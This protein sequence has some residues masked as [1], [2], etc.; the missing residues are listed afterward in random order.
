MLDY[1]N[2]FQKRIHDPAELSK[3]IRSEEEAMYKANPE[4]R[5]AG[6]RLSSLEIPNAF[7]S[8]EYAPSVLNLTPRQVVS[9]HGAKGQTQLAKILIRDIEESRYG[10]NGGFLTDIQRQEIKRVLNWQDMSESIKGITKGS[11]QP[12]EVNGIT[13][14]IGEAIVPLGGKSYYL[15]DLLASKAK[16]K[17]LEELDKSSYTNNMFYE[18]VHRYFGN[19]EPRAVGG[20]PTSIGGNAVGRAATKATA[21]ATRTAVG[22]TV[23]KGAAN[24]ASAAVANSTQNGPSVAKATVAAANAAIANSAPKG[25]S[26]ARS[27]NAVGQAWIINSGK[28]EDFGKFISGIMPSSMDNLGNKLRGLLKGSGVLAIGGA[29]LTLGVMSSR[30][31]IRKSA[32]SILTED[33]QINEPKMDNRVVRKEVPIHKSIHGRIKGV[34]DSNVDP[35][36]I[37]NAVHAAIDMHST[38]ASDKSHVISNDRRKITKQEANKI[39]KKLLR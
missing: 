11:I 17:I 38:G 39:A 30:I 31:G 26:V 33:D 7:M 14:N 3:M 12:V 27:A 34:V 23:N 10:A 21:K 20:A 15:R 35:N 8:G 37:V 4:L 18:A 28:A 24:I 9:I 19:A 13:R 6:L 16:D 2:N 25:P 5:Q 29:L 22:G 36:E 32:P 1:L